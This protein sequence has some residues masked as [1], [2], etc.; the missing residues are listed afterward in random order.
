MESN[1]GAKY[2]ELTLIKVLRIVAPSYS[3]KRCLDYLQKVL[4]QFDLPQASLTCSFETFINQTPHVVIKE[5]QKRFLFSLLVVKSVLCKKD[6][7]NTLVYDGRHAI[8]NSD[9]KNISLHCFV[10][11]GKSRMRLH[12]RNEQ[13][14]PCLHSKVLQ[15]KRFQRVQPLL[16]L[17][18][19]SEI[20]SCPSV[21]DP[22][23]LPS[24]VEFL[25]KFNLPDTKTFIT[26]RYAGKSKLTCCWYTTP[27]FASVPIKRVLYIEAFSDRNYQL[28]YAPVANVKD[29]KAIEN[30]QSQYE[31]YKIRVA[32]AQELELKPKDPLQKNYSSS[33][34]VVRYGL[35]LAF[36]LGLIETRDN[37]LAFSHQLSQ[38]FSSIY[39]FVDD[40]FHLRH[41]NYYDVETHFST[42][43]ACCD[44][45]N[46][47]L[48]M[49]LPMWLQKEEKIRR[50]KSCLQMFSFWTKVWKR[51]ERWIKRREFILKDLIQRLTSMVTRDAVAGKIC[52]S[53]YVKC[54]N[55]MKK[56]IKHQHVYMYSSHDAHMHSVKYYLTDFAYKTFKKCSGVTIKAQNDNTLLSLS[57]FG[58]TIFNLYTYLDCKSDADFF[59]ASC[60]NVVDLGLGNFV[61]EFSPADIFITHQQKDLLLHHCKQVTTKEGQNV[62]LLS[63][64]K[65][66]GRLWAKHILNYW[67]SFGLCLLQSFDHEV[68]SQTTNSSASLLGFQCMWTKCAKMSGPLGH[69]LERSKPFHEFL[70][71]DAS[72]GGFMFSIEGALNQGDVIQSE[73]MPGSGE[74]LC[75]Q[76]IL[77]MDLISSYG[78]AASQALMPTGFCMGFQKSQLDG[79]CLQL[80]D[81]R[82]RYKS[83][84]FRAVYKTL[85]DLLQHKGVLIRTVY[86]NFSPFGIFGLGSYLIDLAVVT[87]KGRLLL[88]QM[89]GAFCHGCDD[90]PP[91]FRYVHGKTQDQVRKDTKI[92]DAFIHSWVKEMNLAAIRH[93]SEYEKEPMVAYQ[94]IQDCCSPGYDSASLSAA[95]L[96]IPALAQLVKGYTIVDQIGK[97]PSICKVMQKIDAAQNNLNFMFIAKAHVTIQKS[98]QQKWQYGPLIVYENRQDKYA[99]QSLAYSGCVVLTRDYYLWL[100]KN[101]GTQLS[102]SS[103]DWILFYP[104]EPRWNDIYEFL[105]QYRSETNDVVMAAF[106]KRI[107]N[108]SA[109]FYAVRSDQPR[110]SRF[111]LVNKLPMDFKFYQHSPD[112]HYCM[113]VGQDSY[114]LLEMKP[115]PKLFVAPSKSA[116]AM[117]LTIV[118]YAKC[119]L[120]ELIHFLQQHIK[121]GCFRLLY[122]NVDNVVF[123]IANADCLADA[124]EPT[125]MSSFNQTKYLYVV[126]GQKKPGLA[127]EKW[128]RLGSSRWKFISI[129]MQHYCLVV[130]SNEEDGLY[131]TSGWSNLSSMEAFQAAEAILKG[132]RVTISQ[133]RRV[134]KL[135]NM[136]VHSVQLSM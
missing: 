30:A 60:P 113:D 19:N 71:R 64:C 51:R 89:D 18:S 73:G 26:F 43:V 62:S 61:N 130:P 47:S 98:P 21:P 84:E 16:Q 53:P 57:V 101:Y 105:T 67:A 45:D 29:K 46:S 128:I 131:K 108:L 40:Q 76:S 104:T 10:V 31:E 107:I 75:A 68:F 15:M 52:Q 5:I 56:I 36:D 135:S 33:V 14:M 70:I 117:H 97:N 65:Y 116:L 13:E 58:L 96:T 20:K 112:V 91:L 92:R 85:Y 41:I 54:L 22:Q 37:L 109:G 124:I 17:L 35:N 55:H 88:Y 126:D 114:F 39:V 106:L 103:I 3:R 79:N 120:I 69:A 44:N 38:T 77:E 127:E 99:K 133:M 95:F 8:F 2:L 94:V 12:T 129:R 24:L 34:H 11:D 115:A 9:A 28:V 42:Q 132:E 87:N 23:N 4:S 125:M 72:K 80:M 136:N 123:C 100:K 134:N 110:R 50:H 81:I 7:V 59:S 1:K 83:F 82:A 122:S 32:L 121:V 48:D 27:S 118:E 111:R 93:S 86:S 90:C 25:Q 74:S 78:Y 119:R 63:F 6:R 102:I 66:K 49:S